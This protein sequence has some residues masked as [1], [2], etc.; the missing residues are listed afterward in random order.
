LPGA[1]EQQDSRLIRGR[2][3]SGSIE[4]KP[5]LDAGFSFV[6]YLAGR[7]IPQGARWSLRRVRSAGGNSLHLLLEQGCCS[8][9]SA[10]SA[11]HEM[12]V[13]P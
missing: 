11:V 3:A 1:E 6:S 2:Q 12:H 5:A 9:V 10:V 4:L 13:I 8:R 7:V